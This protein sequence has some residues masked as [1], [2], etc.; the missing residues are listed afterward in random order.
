MVQTPQPFPLEIA[1]LN[2]HNYAVAA[3]KIDSAIVRA[4]NNFP[5]KPTLY[6]VA[7]SL[8]REELVKV[9][10]ES[11]QKWV[12]LAQCCLNL[13]AL[14]T[15]AKDCNLSKIN[16]SASS[17]QLLLITLNGSSLSASIRSL[18]FHADHGDRIDSVS[19]C[20]QNIFGLPRSHFPRLVPI[21]RDYHMPQNRYTYP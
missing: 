5:P 1:F 16:I 15:V 6:V 18:C 21:R 10:L 13:K 12:K 7:H 4:L 14:Q 19:S 2:S 11:A 17:F 20:T 8:G 3:D 9:L